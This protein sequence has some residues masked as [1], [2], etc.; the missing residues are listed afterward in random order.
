MLGYIKQQA[1]DQNSGNWGVLPL[2][3]GLGGNWGGSYL[4]IPKDSPNAA[5]A[6]QLA[7][8]LTSAESET[9]E[10]QAGLAFP[11]NSESLDQIADVKD[12]YFN[13]AP[14]GQIFSDGFRA[15]PDQ[16]LGVD[17]GTIDNTIGKALTSV[18]SNNV[19]PAEAWDTAMKTL[20]DQIG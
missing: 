8:F 18:E 20:E 10:F 12:P 7:Q 5:A 19:P 16:P 6:A 14:I 17:D 4:S 3:Q 15:A 13:G 1:G 9:K 11:S 2:P